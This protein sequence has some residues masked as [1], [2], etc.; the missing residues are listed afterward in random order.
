MD[1][2]SL[3]NLQ[4]QLSYESF[5]GKDWAWI[6]DVGN[7]SYSSSQIQFD[8]TAF[9]NNRSHFDYSEGFIAIPSIVRL[10]PAA[11]DYPMSA[12]MKNGTVN[13]VDSVQCTLNG[14]SVTNNARGQNI[15]STFRLLEKLSDEAAKMIGPSILYSK[16]SCD[17]QV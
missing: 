14:T 9:G 17:S 13:L 8:G 6:S 1:S 5:A 12:C 3:S 2:E 10:T 4:N 15:V 11:A 7:G 16:D